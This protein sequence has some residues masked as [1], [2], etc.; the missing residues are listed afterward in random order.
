MACYCGTRGRH[1]AYAYTGYSNLISKLNFVEHDDR[2]ESPRYG[3]SITRCY[4][5]YRL[6][7]EYLES[8][9]E[10]SIILETP[11]TVIAAGREWEC[12]PEQPSTLTPAL[13][14]LRRPTESVTAF[15]SGDLEVHFADG[16]RLWA[17]SHGSFEAWAVNTSTGIKIIAQPGG[18]YS[19]WGPT[20]A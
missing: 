4:L 14:L 8:P 5:D 17:P 9:D 19:F 18:S 7:L 3:D 20:D 15:K 10:L 6:T 11:F 1:K 12:E 13:E 2:I 16:S